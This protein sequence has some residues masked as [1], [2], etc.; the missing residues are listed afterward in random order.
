M[1]E[2][3]QVVYVVSGMVRIF[4]RKSPVEYAAL[5]ES[6]GRLGLIEPIHMWRGVVVDGFHRLL[7]CLELSIE[8]RF[9]ILPDDVDPLEV[10]ADKVM[11]ERML[12]ETARAAAAVTAIGRPKPG[13]PL[14]SRENRANLRGFRTRKWGADKFRVGE[15]TIT[16]MAKILNPDSGSIPD[17]R[18]SAREEL[19]TTNDAL[20]TLK[21]DP[22]IQQGAL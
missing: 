18:R 16:T 15:R 7:A 22:E 6:I 3:L 2:A 5:K 1:N 14:G 19:I 9:Q 10:V 12:N 11:N 17:L 4:P 20:R 13:R 8:P 21:E